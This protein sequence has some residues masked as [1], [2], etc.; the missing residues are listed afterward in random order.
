[1]LCQGPLAGP[2][3]AWPT[4]GFPSRAA[5][6][7]PLRIL[8]QSRTCG[9]RQWPSRAVHP[10]FYSPGL[11]QGEKPTAQPG[12]QPSPDSQ[13][14]GPGPVPSFLPRGFLLLSPAETAEIQGWPKTGC[15]GEGRGQGTLPRGQLSLQK[16]EAA[17]RIPRQECPGHTEGSRRMPAAGQTRELLPSPQSS[18]PLEKGCFGGAPHPPRTQ[19]QIS[20]TLS[21]WS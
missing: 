6:L 16:S 19:P 18:V 11:G 21:A 5:K 12:G 14:P 17:C 2:N 1:M 4:G 8:G 3:G 20:R 10:P 9:E 7:Q 13:A 15:R